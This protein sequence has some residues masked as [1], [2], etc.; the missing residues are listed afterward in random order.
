M[1]PFCRAA[2]PVVSRASACAI[3]L[4]GVILLIADIIPTLPGG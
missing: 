2:A 1:L 4:C 3:Y